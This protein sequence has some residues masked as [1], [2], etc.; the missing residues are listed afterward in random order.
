MTFKKPW[1][2]QSAT[3]AVSKR[4]YCKAIVEVLGGKSG[5]MTP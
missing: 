2:P 4:R 3:F 5:A 1:C